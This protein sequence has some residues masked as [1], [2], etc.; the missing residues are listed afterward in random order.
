LILLHVVCLIN[1]SSSPAA[2]SPFFSSAVA[3]SRPSLRLFTRLLEPS[4]YRTVILPAT[5]YYKYFSDS[6]P[7]S[8][9]EEAK[10]ESNMGVANAKLRILH[11]RYL[12]VKQSTVR[13]D[14]EQI[15]RII[16]YLCINIHQVTPSEKG[17]QSKGQAFEG[18]TCIQGTAVIAAILCNIMAYMDYK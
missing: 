3:I 9:G 17:F 13:L 11:H 7:K 14:S 15:F 10:W 5:L 1:P 8:S 4:A 6:R 12:R 16:A 2:V 18:Y